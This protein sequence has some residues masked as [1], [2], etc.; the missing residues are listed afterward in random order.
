MALHHYARTFCAEKLSVGLFRGDE[1]VGVAVLGIPVRA[2]VLTGPFPGLEPF[3]ASAELSRFVL[4]DDVPANGET[5]LI[6]QLFGYL[7]RATA[8][9]GVV[10]FSDPYPRRDAQGTVRM[11][12]HWGHIYIAGNATFLGRST[13]RTI[14]LLPDATVLNERSQAKVRARD[15]GWQH[16]AGRL[17]DLGA[18]APPPGAWTGTSAS[19]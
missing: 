17:V 19:A 11:P 4:L 7:R 18:A 5:Y 9:R 2:E 16:V 15:R 3:T 8:I 6:G 13:P 12:G 14:C 10:A 1:L